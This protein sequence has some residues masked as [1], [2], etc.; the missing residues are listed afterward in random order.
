MPAKL[1]KSVGSL[2]CCV[3]LFFGVFLWPPF[4]F[5]L[6]LLASTAAIDVLT[7]PQV[8]AQLHRKRLPLGRSN[9]SARLKK[10]TSLPLAYITCT[11]W[12]GFSDS[13]T[14]RACCNMD[15]LGMS[16]STV[17]ASL[18]MKC[19]VCVKLSIRCLVSPER[20]GSHESWVV[21]LQYHPVAMAIWCGRGG[22]SK[23]VT[24]Y[25]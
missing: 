21:A 5:Y 11:P 22:A 7:K 1:F 4:V 3:I 23:G 6:F 17:G 18:P 9:S 13:N 24:I 15:M 25:V 19:E 12:A 10:K 8:Y 16:P 14:D 20:T 2:I